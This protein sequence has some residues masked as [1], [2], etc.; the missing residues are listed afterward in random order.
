MIDDELKRLIES[1]AA[2]TRRHFDVSTEELKH[3]IKLLAGSLAH[4]DAKVDRFKLEI[5]DK[6]D[7]G[8]TETQAMIKFSHAE[9]DRR[10]RALELAIADLQTRVERLE[11]TTH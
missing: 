5:E 4:V 9:L 2:E 10:V 3:E 11:T 1:S 8:F 7:R 6:M